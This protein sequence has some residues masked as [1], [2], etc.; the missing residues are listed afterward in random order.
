VT[1]I[2]IEHRK[3]IE[4]TARRKTAHQYESY[5][6]LQ[7]HILE[8][9]RHYARLT[10]RQLY[11]ILISKY[12]YAPSRKFYKIL[13]Y[14]LTKM[15]RL[16]PDLHEK[17]AD[18]SR[19][20]IL[21]PLP[22]SEIELWVEKDSIRNFLG[23]LAA[24]YRLSI[25]VF[26]GF[27]SLSMFRKALLRAAKRGVRL[28]LYL[29]DHDASGLAIQKLAA[30][31]MRIEVKR[32][33]LTLQQAKRYKL[34]ALVVNKRDSR[35]KDYIS[36]YGNQC[37]EVEALRPRTF[38]RLVD[39]QLRQNVPPQY[40]LEAEKRERATRVVKPLTERLRKIIE[41]EAFQMLQQGK[42]E[43]EIAA[44]IVPKYDVIFKETFNPR[45][46]RS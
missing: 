29:G 19:A 3:N 20:F 46:L 7:W 9:A 24:K 16:N 31:E 18:P 13:D 28:I 12:R 4:S 17:F 34:P 22:Y 8:T 42:S 5:G 32:I 40:L 23:T 15:R 26:R 36:K 21:A 43:K 37:W 38:L 14:H 25:Q 39:E 33:A 27:A 11:Y 1:A 45:E 30:K 10:V 35:A 41:Q 44:L 2:P 6:S